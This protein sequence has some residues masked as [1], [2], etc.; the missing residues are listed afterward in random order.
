MMEDHVGVHDSEQVLGH[1]G[2][3]GRIVEIAA[4]QEIHFWIAPVH[5]LEDAVSLVAILGP[6]RAFF[7]RETRGPVRRQHHEIVAV[8]FDVPFQNAKLPAVE[9]GLVAAHRQAGEDRRAMCRPA[10]RSFINRFL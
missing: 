8:Y 6:L 1:A 4:D 9:L 7:V 2:R 5:R 10:E 3:A